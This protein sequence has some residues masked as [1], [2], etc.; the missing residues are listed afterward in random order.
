MSTAEDRELKERIARLAGQINRHKNQQAGFVPE[1]PVR[2]HHRKPTA[3]R[4]ADRFHNPADPRRDAGHPTAWRRGGFP[5]RGGHHSTRMPVYRNKTLILNGGS[6]QNQNGDADSGAT[7][8]AS[9]SSWVTKHDRHLQLINTNVYKKDAEARTHAIEQTRRQKLALR[10]RQERAKLINHLGRI[11]NSG[12]FGINKQAANDKY[13]IAVQG[14]RFIVA[15]N[16]SKLIRAPGASRCSEKTIQGTHTTA[17][18]ANSAKATPKMADIGGVK[19]YRSK[20]GNLY[21]HGIV[22]AQ[23]YVLQSHATDQLTP[24]FLG[25]R[26]GAVKKVNVPCKQF[27]MTGN[28]IFLDRRPTQHLPRPGLGSCAQG[29]RCRYVH[30]PH[31]VAICK[32]FLQQGECANGA[33]CDLSHDPT[34]ERTPACLHFARDSCT[35]ADC[36][37]AHVKVSPAAPVCRDFGLYGYCPRGAACADRHA[38][39][40]PDF[41]NTGACKTRGCKLPHR[42]RASVL[43]RRGTARDGDD[44]EM[45]DL[46]SDDEDGESI[47]DDDVDS[48]EVDEFIGQD[49]SGALDFAEQKDFIEL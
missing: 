29:P 48:D 32:D 27:S 45:A 12:S 30:D 11:A 3:D 28:S 24:A 37:Y 2:A 22:K 39:E 35:K 10:D 34:P 40:C 41:S 25:R 20:N 13:E 42:E 6:Q 36:K 31:K 4:P 26:S 8:D 43:L 47:D 5:S 19:F 46:S 38:F 33:H 15:K 18:D 44:A 49:E 16:G 21:R 7:S 17:G 1:P 14:V 23:R 9:N